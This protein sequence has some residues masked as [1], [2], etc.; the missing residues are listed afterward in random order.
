MLNDIYQQS[1]F[2]VNFCPNKE[3]HN[4]ITWGAA[5]PPQLSYAMGVISLRGIRNTC[6]N[7]QLNTCKVSTKGKMVLSLEP[8]SQ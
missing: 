3:L 8:T 1:Q 4:F 6:I 2:F 7:H 5:A